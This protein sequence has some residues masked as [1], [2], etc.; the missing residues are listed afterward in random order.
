MKTLLSIV[1]GFSMLLSV[2]AQDIG[3]I[4]NKGATGS[5]SAT[6]YIDSGNAAAVKITD[7][8]CK[9]DAANTSA[10]IDIRQGRKSYTSTSATSSST[11]VYFDNS[12]S[13]I[14]QGDYLLFEDVSAGSLT[15]CRVTAA[16]AAS[17]TTQQTLSAATNDKVWTLAAAVRRPVGDTSISGT[18]RVQDI[19]LPGKEPSAI[20][21]EGNTTACKVSLS[22]VRL[23]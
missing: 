11:V 4:V 19:Y 7:L 5:A 18:A 14:A 13:A 17:A 21:L 12:T 1:L 3:G 20:T 23:K 8:A 22:G 6:V 2:N 9:L 10:T 15:L 16:A